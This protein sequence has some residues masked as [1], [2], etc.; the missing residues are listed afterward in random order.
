[1]DTSVLAKI[2]LDLYILDP[3]SVSSEMR[4]LQADNF[5]GEPNYFPDAPPAQ[6]E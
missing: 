5:V 2:C 1:M 4:W 6:I 3:L